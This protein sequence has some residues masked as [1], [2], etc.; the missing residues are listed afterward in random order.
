MDLDILTSKSGPRK[1]KSTKS[2]RALTEGKKCFEY[3][4]LGHFARDCRNKNK[5]V[6]KDILAA[7]ILH[8]NAIIVYFIEDLSTD[9]CF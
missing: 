2:T 4:K 8:L 5:I 6:K 7:I 3:N 1:K 9:K